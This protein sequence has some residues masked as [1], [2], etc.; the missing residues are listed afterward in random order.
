L[1]GEL[2]GEALIDEKRFYRSG[3]TFLSVLIGIADID[4][5]LLAQFGRGDVQLVTRIGRK[6]QLPVC[7]DVFGNDARLGNGQVDVVLC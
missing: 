4:V 2:R 5:R 3:G 6:I 7:V 1:N